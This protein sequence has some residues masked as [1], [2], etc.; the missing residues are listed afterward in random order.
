MATMDLTTTQQ[1]LLIILSAA[2]AILLVLAIAVAILI[3]QLLRTLRQVAQKAEHVVE[4]A[5]EVGDVFRRA[6][7]PLGALKFLQSVI[8]AAVKHRNS[9]K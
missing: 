9:Q 6:A 7:G 2:L 3:I 8:E 5:E 4:S 1:V